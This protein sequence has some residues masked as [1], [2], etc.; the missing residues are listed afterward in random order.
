MAKKVFTIKNV[1]RR[2]QTRLRRASAPR[3]LR[4]KQY[5]GGRRLLRNQVMRLS[6]EQF[7]AVRDEVIKGIE[8]GALE[9]VDPDGVKHSADALGR[10]VH[11]KGMVAEAADVPKPTPAPPP[12]PP[13]PKKE[14]PKK[15]PPPPKA[16][17]LTEL[18]GVGTGRAKKLEA[19]GIKTFSHIAEMAPGKLAKILGPPTTEDQAAEI[20]DAASKKGG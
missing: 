9:M 17:T 18:P 4:F 10:V 19:A 15:A 16:D 14:E 13:E 20:C 3:R 5:I 1:V 7:E 12:P 6:P 2:V 11:R 8:C